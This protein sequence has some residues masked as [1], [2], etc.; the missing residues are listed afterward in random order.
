MMRILSRT[1]LVAAFFGVALLA[2]SAGGRPAEAA[3]GRVSLSV[4]GVKRTAVLVEF[5]R[6][7]KRRRPVIIV[8]HGSTVASG[9]A[10]R[11]RR[12]LGVESFARDMG[13]IV[14]Y[15]DAQDGSWLRPKPGK[16]EPNDAAFVRALATR[17]IDQ[18]VANPR[19]IYVA[20]ISV[21]GMLAMKVACEHADLFAGAGA[22]VANMPADIGANCAPSRPISFLL[23]NGT[24]DPMMPYHGGAAQLAGGPRD[25]LSTEATLAIFAKAAQCTGQRS[26]TYPDR[27]QND[28]SRVIVE[29]G[30]G[31]KAPVELVRVEGGGHTIP[32]RRR[33]AAR[34]LPVGAQ[35]NDIEG[36]RL[37]WDFLFK[38]SQ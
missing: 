23:M 8:L 30:T 4:D 28:G 3:Y 10:L 26:T 7:K 20:G 37:M 22:F 5:E 12:N 11:A 35:N 19:R 1:S 17:L 13:A 24:A 32:G 27:D 2:L 33:T 15:P 31:C 25:V 14:V 29:R 36:A 16:P 21:G 9:A 6:L 38:H 18:G 34:G